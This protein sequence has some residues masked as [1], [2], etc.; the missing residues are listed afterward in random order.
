MSCKILFG[1]LVL[2]LIVSAVISLCSGC[3]TQ[4]PIIMDAGDIE[5]LRA[6]CEYY[7][8]EYNRIHRDYQRLIEDQQFYA[9][10]YQHTTAAINAGIEEL[11]V[12]GADSLTEIARLRSYISVLKRIIFEILDG[13]RTGQANDIETDPG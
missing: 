8:N 2:M 3:S 5:Q 12:L 10:Y 9:D 1:I 11:A 4:Q 13:E 6:E 7:R